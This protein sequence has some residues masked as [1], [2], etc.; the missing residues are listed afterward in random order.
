MMLEVSVA[1]ERF[2]DPDRQILSP[3]LEHGKIPGLVTAAPNTTPTSGPSA[4]VLILICVPSRLSVALELSPRHHSIHRLE[5]SFQLSSLSNE[6]SPL[7][8]W[9]RC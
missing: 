1:Q 8:E 7:L 9:H 4:R 2:P 5:S 6:L 3:L